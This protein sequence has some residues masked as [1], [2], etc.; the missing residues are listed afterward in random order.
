MRSSLRAV[1]L[2]EYTTL[3]DNARSEHSSVSRTP[4]SRSCGISLDQ[5][6]AASAD[7]ALRSSSDQSQQFC[8]FYTGW[9]ATKSRQT[10]LPVRVDPFTR[11]AA[12]SWQVSPSENWLFKGGHLTRV[13][14]D[15]NSSLVD[16]TNFVGDNGGN[17]SGQLSEESPRRFLA[18]CVGT[19]WYSD[20][21]FDNIFGFSRTLLFDVTTKSIIGRIDGS[22]FI[23]AA[24]SPSGR[25]IAFLKGEKVR[26]YDA[27]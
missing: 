17:C 9:P 19:H 14:T 10:G 4:L 25:R 20:G 11:A 24:L 13:S 23:S 16:P 26:P 22:A 18:T 3:S 2:L 15:G 8:D 6:S 7:F 5:S 27:P 21:M 1:E 12:N